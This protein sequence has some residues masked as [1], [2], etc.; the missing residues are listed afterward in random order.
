MADQAQGSKN[1]V[2]KPVDPPAAAA[3]D[4]DPIFLALL[5]GVVA[6]SG[7]RVSDAKVQQLVRTTTAIRAA[8]TK[9]TA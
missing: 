9:P 6:R 1:T 7:E 8:L 5:S 3:P 2:N 4:V